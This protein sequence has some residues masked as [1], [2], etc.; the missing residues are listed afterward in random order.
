MST[1][2][3]LEN[4]QTHSLDAHTS[5][6]YAQNHNTRKSTAAAIPHNSISNQIK[7][8]E[9]TFNNDVFVLMCFFAR[10]SL[11]LSSLDVGLETIVNV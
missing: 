1:E 5:T 10:S 7:S 6:T 2:A 11:K 9:L 8:I 4:I 3:T